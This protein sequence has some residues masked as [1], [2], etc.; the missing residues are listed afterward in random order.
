MLQSQS[1][2]YWWLLGS[3]VGQVLCEDAPNPLPLYKADA[4]MCWEFVS[5]TDHAHLIWISKSLNKDDLTHRGI[6]LS[7]HNS[8]WAG[9]QHGLTD[10]VTQDLVISGMLFRQTKIPACLARV[11]FQ[12]TKSRNTCL[13]FGVSSQ[14]WLNFSSFLKAEVQSRWVIPV[15]ALKVLVAGVVVPRQILY[16]TWN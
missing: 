5:D 4:A 6:S 7:V 3:K 13:I 14:Q 9:K 8:S 2:G 15:D 10:W 12:T 11:F 1:C 16:D